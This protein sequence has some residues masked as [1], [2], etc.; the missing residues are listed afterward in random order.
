MRG[1]HLLFLGALWAALACSGKAKDVTTQE[2]QPPVAQTKEDAPPA[3]PNADPTRARVTLGELDIEGSRNGEEVIAMAMR[4]AESLRKCYEDRLAKDDSLEG[5]VAIRVFIS[6]EGN[7]DDALINNSKL[8]DHR[9]GT[10]MLRAAKK[11]KL[12]EDPSGAPSRVTVPVVFA[13]P[14][15]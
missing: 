5:E 8:K 10:C 15:G 4:D 11:W 12:P 6:A 9:V 1:H 2:E 14:E 13:K 7:V 3:D